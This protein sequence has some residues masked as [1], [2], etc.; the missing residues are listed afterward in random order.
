MVVVWVGR[1]VEVWW[2]ERWVGV[3]GGRVVEV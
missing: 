2:V 3:V 1:V